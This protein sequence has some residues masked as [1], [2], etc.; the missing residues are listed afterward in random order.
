MAEPIRLQKF[1]TDCGVLSR[2]AAEAEILAGKVRIN[3]RVAQLGD[4]VDPET[5]R[6]EYLGKPLRPRRSTP[7]LYLMLNKPRGYV[8]T[9]KDEKGRK[10]VTDLTRNAGSRVY[11]V[12]RLDMD[13]DGLLLLTDDGAFAN[14]L[15]HPRHEIPKI[16]HVTLAKTPTREQLAALAAPMELDGYALQPV[17][18]RVLSPTELE[19]TLYEGRNRQ[20]RRMCE[21]VDLKITRLQRVAIGELSLGDLPLGKWRL[22]TPDE[23]AYLFPQKNNE[24][25]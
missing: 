4:R 14:H 10:N 7:Y 1:F 2:R 20:I 25:K 6:V 5:D 21:A 15:T 22:L 8:S 9:A 19:M 18:V 24:N 3:G 17:G 16:Y 23:V 12:G 11:P 13:S